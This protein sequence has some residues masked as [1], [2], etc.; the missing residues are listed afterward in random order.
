MSEFQKLSL[1]Q[2]I[3]VKHPIP[4][5]TTRRLVIIIGLNLRNL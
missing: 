5:T 4:V 2:P 3:G 1:V